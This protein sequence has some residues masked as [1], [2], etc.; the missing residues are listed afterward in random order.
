M[1]AIG[2]RKPSN[3]L[4]SKVLKKAIESPEFTLQRP[5]KGDSPAAFLARVCSCVGVR[6]TFT[7][8]AN[9]SLPERLNALI[10][11]SE[12]TALVRGLHAA[13]EAAIAVARAQFAESDDLSLPLAR[14][15]SACANPK[16]AAREAAQ[17]EK[18]A[19]V[20][21]NMQ[22]TP[23]QL[24]TFASIREPKKLF[25]F[26]KKQGS[27]SQFIT[28][29]GVIA[30]STRAA[31]GGGASQP[32]ASTAKTINP[33]ESVLRK[34]LERAMGN[35]NFAL[36]DFKDCENPADVLNSAAA[37]AGLPAAFEMV[38]SNFFS[39]AFKST[40]VSIMNTEAISWNG[41]CLRRICDAL[42]YSVAIA[43]FV[44]N[45]KNGEPN[46]QVICRAWFDILSS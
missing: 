43:R 1:A 29:M 28:K 15:R 33:F 21:T 11:S 41:K 8:S 38:P 46:T 13:M 7:N 14:W 24:T 35:S 23:R 36:P 40:I 3:I 4:L 39:R 20:I 25:H 44:K 19:E 37:C 31:D 2:A 6:H 10:L 22:L 5:A 34:I 26:L 18:H 9:T 17:A 42:K 16:L 30:A 12:R 45:G 32:V 27:F